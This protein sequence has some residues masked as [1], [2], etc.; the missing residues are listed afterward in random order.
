MAFNEQ[1]AFVTIRD[2][3][4]TYKNFN[5]DEKPF[6]EAG[7]RN[8]SLVLGEEDATDLIAKGWNVRAMRM[9]EEDTEQYYHLSIAV[10]Y[11]YKPPRVYLIT[12][13]GK[14]KALLGESLV[15]MLDQLEYS[16]V[17]LE[18]TPYDWKMA[19]KTGKKAYLQTMFF[20]MLE[21]PLELEYADVEEIPSLGDM[22]QPALE[23]SPDWVEGEVVT[24]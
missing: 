10:N 9:G 1:R 13:Q 20:H 8:F 24:D 5:G 12:A 14:K 23:A 11:R 7:K 22:A 18:F 2:A 3:E 19:G 15:G 4:I 16:K 6:N 21:S 17:D